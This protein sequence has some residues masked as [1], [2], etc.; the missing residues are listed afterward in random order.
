MLQSGLMGLLYATFKQP[1]IHAIAEHRFE[2]TANTANIS[3][4]MLASTVAKVQTCTN[5]G[6]RVAAQL[7]SVFQKPWNLETLLQLDHRSL[8]T[9]PHN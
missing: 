6:V 8:E 4:S 9:N 7:A 3:A 5:G 2:V 1:C